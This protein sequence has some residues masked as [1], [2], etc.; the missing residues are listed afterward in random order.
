MTGLE[1]AVYLIGAFL[2]ANVIIASA[3]LGSEGAA[4]VELFIALLAAGLSMAVSLWRRTKASGPEFAVY[5]LGSA[6]L[7]LI[8]LIAVLARSGASG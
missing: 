6:Y 7:L 4:G 3:M 5:G 8:A 2:I 1:S